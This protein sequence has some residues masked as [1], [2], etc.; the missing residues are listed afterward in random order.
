MRTKKM[1]NATE[2]A[3]ELV[4]NKPKVIDIDRF[5]SHGPGGAKTFIDEER[6]SINASMTLT[7]NAASTDV[8]IA[9]GNVT[10]SIYADAA[11]AIAALGADYLLSDGTIATV[12]TDKDITAVSNDAD[13]TIDQLIKYI[14]KN[15]TRIVRLDLESTDLSGNADT[16]NYAQSIKSAWTSPFVKPVEKF[17]QLRKF[18][19][20]NKFQPQFAEVNFLK[21]GFEVILS[22]EHFF[23]FTLKASTEFTMTWEIGMQDSKAQRFYRQVKAADSALANLRS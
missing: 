9:I 17:L 23:V 3:K 2:V 18:Q 16:S 20:G 6:G 22:N 10:D 12:E 8:V 1:V 7:N 5:Y 14:G 19:S 13:R 15:P 21:E 4:M 11:E